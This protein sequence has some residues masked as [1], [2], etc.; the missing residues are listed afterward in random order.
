VTTWHPLSAKVGA[1]FADKGRS[2]G[3]VSSLTQ[4]T[5]S[6][7]YRW[8]QVLFTVS[9]P[10]PGFC[11]FIT[12]MPVRVAVGVQAHAILATQATNYNFCPNLIVGALAAVCHLYATAQ[13]Q[14]KYKRQFTIKRQ[15]KTANLSVSRSQLPSGLGHELFSPAPTLRSW[16]RIPLRHGCLFVFCVRFFCFHSLK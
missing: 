7:D 1:N 12:S 14:L 5:E 15:R 10:V 2:V 16:V 4:A 13:P 3:K 9:A 8:R 11:F 6:L